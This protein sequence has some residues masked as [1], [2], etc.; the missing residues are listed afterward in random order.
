MRIIK[1]TTPDGVTS[2]LPDSD[3]GYI[4]EA[5]TREVWDK[6]NLYSLRNDP[7]CQT[8]ICRGFVEPLRPPVTLFTPQGIALERITVQLKR[9]NMCH[10]GMFKFSAG[11]G[12]RFYFTT[13]VKNL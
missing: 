6:Q 13:K 3:E 9:C 12:Q 8:D 5:S 4:Y 10:T 7:V 2:Y 11:P 1:T